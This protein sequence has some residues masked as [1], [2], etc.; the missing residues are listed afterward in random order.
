M[1]F[2]QIIVFIWH[3]PKARGQSAVPPRG[4]TIFRCIYSRFPIFCLNVSCFLKSFA[5]LSLIRHVYNNPERRKRATI[6]CFLK[7]I[8]QVVR[9]DV[10]A[11][12]T[13]LGFHS[14]GRNIVVLRF[15]GQRTIEM[16]GLVGSKDWPVSNWTQQVPTLLWFHANGRNKSQHCWLLANNVGSVCIMDL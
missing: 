2:P 10:L 6:V 1:F 16:L 8:L 12:P 11:K 4:L 15:A 3:A 13:L 9:A 14:N 7:I 5:P